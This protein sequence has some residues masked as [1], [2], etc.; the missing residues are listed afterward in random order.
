MQIGSLTIVKNSP[1]NTSLKWIGPNL[2]LLL[3]GLIQQMTQ[4]TASDQGLI[5]FFFTELHTN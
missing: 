4:N 2:T 3:S 1:T 5:F